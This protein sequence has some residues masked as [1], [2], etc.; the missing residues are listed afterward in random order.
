MIEINLLPKELQKKKKEIPE[1]P[2]LPIGIGILAVLILSGFILLP[3]IGY[4]Q[5]R[6]EKLTGQMKEKAPFKK[7]ALKLQAEIK[8]LKSKEQI[9]DQLARRKFFW[10]EKL[11]LI[12]DLVPMGAWL[13]NISFKETQGGGGFLIL[14][15]TAIPYKKQEMINLVTLFMKNLKE[16]N[17]FYNDF[18]IIELG[19]IRRIKID[20]TEA[21]QFNLSCQFKDANLR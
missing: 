5:S 3:V 20:N 7:E 19:P 9:I 4:Y 15:G 1:I 2:L 17:T 21:M 16:N 13:T 14:D 12:S 11:N 10:A 8:R 18:E 6:V